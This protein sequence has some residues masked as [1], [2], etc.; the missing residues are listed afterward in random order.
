MDPATTGT[1]FDDKVGAKWVHLAYRG[2]T[3]AAVEANGTPREM[4][5]LYVDVY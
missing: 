5:M 1:I 3:L 4:C 2:L